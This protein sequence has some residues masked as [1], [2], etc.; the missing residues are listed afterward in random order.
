[1]DERTGPEGET[2]YVD[3]EDAERG[4]DGPLSKPP[5]PGQIRRPEGP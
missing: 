5:A 1:M 2:L 4:A 3:T